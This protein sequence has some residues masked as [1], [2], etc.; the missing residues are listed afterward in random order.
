MCAVAAKFEVRSQFNQIL[1]NIYKLCFSKMP[2]FAHALYFWF[3]LIFLIAR[4][5]AVSLYAAEV[6]DEAK[7]PIF[8]FRSVPRESWCFEVSNFL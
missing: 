6:N 3:S 5:L 1:K 8:V 2:S 4:T 7:K